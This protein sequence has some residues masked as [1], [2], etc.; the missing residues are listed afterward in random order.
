LLVLN[1]IGYSHALLGNYE[2]ALSCCERALA[3]GREFGE[4]DWVKAT[5]HSLGYIHHRLGDHRQAIAFYEQSLELCRKLADRYDEAETLVNVG[6]VYH[7][8]GD[9]AAARREWTRALRIYEEIG[10]PGRD[11]LRAKLRVDNH[12][13]ATA[14]R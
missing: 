14:D 5:L 1:D 2:E 9:R 7:S 3:A 13:M 4:H 10:H 8:A 12:A 11:L 6:E